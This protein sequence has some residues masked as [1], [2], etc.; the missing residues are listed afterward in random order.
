MGDCCPTPLTRT[1]DECGVLEG[2]RFRAQSRAALGQHATL[3]ALRPCDRSRHTPSRLAWPPVAIRGAET[4]TN[5][6]LRVQLAAR[7]GTFPA[8]GCALHRHR[9]KCCSGCAPTRLRASLRHA[10]R[11]TENVVDVRLTGMRRRRRDNSTLP[12]HTAPHGRLGCKVALEAH[13]HA[14]ST[15]PSVHCVAAR[16]HEAMAKRLWRT[17]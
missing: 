14:H 10:N 13:A 12:A 8:R 7:R 5:D 3:V 17:P 4:L 1:E 2:A 11:P 16:A 9:E 6:L 15:A